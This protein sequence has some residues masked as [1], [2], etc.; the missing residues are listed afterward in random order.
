[1]NK[2]IIFYFLIIIT[3]NLM[4][5]STYFVVDISSYGTN[6][7]SPTKV[8]IAPGDQKVTINDVAFIEYAG[9]VAKALSK[10]GFIVVNNLDDADQVVLLWYAISD[11]KSQTINIPI[12]GPTGISSSSTFGYMNSS[13][14][15]FANTNYDYQYGLKGFV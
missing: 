6:V 7:T 12:Y 9:Y 10:N 11:P 14:N 5:C 4:G 8:F 3:S 2:N 13:G 1:M 15:F